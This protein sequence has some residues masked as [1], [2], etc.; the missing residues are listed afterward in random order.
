M[1]AGLEHLPEWVQERIGRASSKGQDG[2][3][4]ARRL[5]RAEAL[6]KANP[7]LKA[8]ET[9]GIVGVLVRAA[10]DPTRYYDAAWN[11]NSNWA[12][13]SCPDHKAAPEGLCKHLLLAAL[14]WAR[15]G[16][17]RGMA[18][19]E[20]ARRYT[21]RGRD[22]ED[23]LDQDAQEPT[24]HGGQ[25]RPDTG[26]N[27]VG[28]NT[29][30]SE[31]SLDGDGRET[32]GAHQHERK[33]V[34]REMAGY[35]RLES[36]QAAEVEFRDLQA[37]Q[38][39]THWVDDKSVECTGANCPHC[40]AGRR[41]R[42]KYVYTVRQGEREFIWEVGKRG[43]EA[44]QAAARATGLN[45]FRAMLIRRGDG[46]QTAYE[47]RDVRP[48]PQAEN[49]KPVASTQPE[50]EHPAETKQ[51]TTAKGATDRLTYIASLVRLLIQELEEVQDSLTEDE[52]FVV[53]IL[54]TE[55]YNARP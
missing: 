55:V 15:N 1:Q 6:L 46:I 42:E 28:G 51:E 32:E 29:I 21:V 30:T 34:E 53:R 36:G 43:H 23:H 38:V 16:V 48:L 4:F 11:N 33:G 41:P 25:I 19:A 24:G 22:G 39:G 3:H 17:E 47:V 9:A 49:G 18:T 52:E 14:A 10:G 8:Y 40:K 45:A 26:A 2:S 7:G 37:K 20:Y 35:L 54:L 27:P 50:R 12:W 44:V 31:A 5:A 13:C